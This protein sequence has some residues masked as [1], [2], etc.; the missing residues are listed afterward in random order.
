MYRKF[1]ANNK[2]INKRDLIL[3][4]TFL[5]LI[6]VGG[7]FCLHQDVRTGA[8]DKIKD[9]FSD[10]R[11]KAHIGEEEFKESQ[12]ASVSDQ[13]SLETESQDMTEELTEEALSLGKTKEVLGQETETTLPEKKKLTLEEIAEQVNEISKKVVL[14]SIQVQILSLEDISSQIDKGED[15]GEGTLEQIS[16]RIDQV[17]EKIESISAQL[18]LLLSQQ[19]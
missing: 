3:L 8:I 6:L 9:Y 11:L 2:K 5:V 4:A 14:V 10:L 19:P 13:M 7:Y 16:E 18:E 15:I 1:F 17:S 12:P